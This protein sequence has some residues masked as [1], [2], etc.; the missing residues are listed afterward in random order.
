MTLAAATGTRLTVAY[1]ERI[2]SSDGIPC[3]MN[4]QASVTVSGEVLGDS[5]FL[6][7]IVGKSLLVKLL[8]QREGIRPADMAVV[9]TW[10]RLLGLPAG[11]IAHYTKNSLEVRWVNPSTRSLQS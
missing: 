4:P 7:C 6:G 10:L 1:C 11:L 8:S 2:F 3:Q 9:Q 5:Q